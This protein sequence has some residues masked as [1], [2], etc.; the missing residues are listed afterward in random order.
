M[1]AAGMEREGGI[2][3]SVPRRI[4]RPCPEVVA[5]GKAFCISGTRMLGWRQ[6]CESRDHVLFDHCIS[7]T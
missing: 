7:G 5:S 2:R 6:G 4:H 3:E 1:N